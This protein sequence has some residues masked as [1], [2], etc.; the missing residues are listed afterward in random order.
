VITDRN[1]DGWVLRE[2]ASLNADHTVLMLAG[3]LCS[4]AFFDDLMAEPR[5][6]EGSIRLVAATLPGFAGTKPPDD[7]SM[8]NYA[9]LANKLAADL[10]CDAVVGHSV[11]ANIAI[12][13]A[14]AGEF[15]GPLALLSPSFSRRDESRFPRAL[16]RIGVVLGH[17]PFAAMLKII[18]VAMRGSLPADRHD[19]LV[20]EMKKNDPR[21]VRR[22]TRRYLEYLDRHRSL[23]SRLSNAGVKSWIVF[24]ERDDVGLTGEERRELEECALVTLITIAGAGH[25]TMNQEPARIADIIIEMV[26]V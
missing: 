17:L 13:M 1:R 26:A 14:A 11:G 23:V 21:F 6:A 3:A 24:G 2:S 15:S 4:A 22:Q 16:D 19:A 18:G 20:A 10:G 8:E 9:K 7:L 12:E 5:L 25:F